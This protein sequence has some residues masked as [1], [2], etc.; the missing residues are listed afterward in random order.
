MA[1][2]T[3]TDIANLQNESSAVTVLAS[4]NTATEI[5]LENT[6]SRDGLTPNH[7]NSELDMNSNRIINLPDATTEQEPITYGQFLETSAAIEAGA[8]LTG[9][10]IVAEAEPALGSSRILTAGTGINIIDEGTT[11]T[12]ESSGLGSDVVTLNDT[13]TLTNKTLT[14]PTL[15]SPVLG[16]PAAA[17]LINATG[18]PLSTGVVGNLAVANLN[19][20]T[21][22]SSSTFWRGDGTWST[23]AVPT[24]VT[25]IAGTS[26]VITLG[27]GLS[28]AGSVLSGGSSK[29]YILN[30]AM[31]VSQENG[32]AVGTGNGYY[33]VDQFNWGAGGWTGSVNVAQVASRTPSGS[34][35]RIRATIT[36]ADASVGAS[37]FLY[38]RTTLEGTK[39]ADLNFGSASAKTV[40]LQFGVKAPAG[41]YAV[42]FRNAVPDR[43]WKGEYTIT[44][45]ETNTDVV[46]SVTLTVDTTGTWTTGTTLG[47]N[48][49]WTLMAG[50]TFTSSATGWFSASGELA[51]SSQFNFAGTLGN[52]FEL[53]DVSLTQGSTAPTF[54]V[55]DFEEELNRCKRYWE[56]SWDYST[57]V[58]TS[59]LNG[60]EQIYIY[61]PAGFVQG[62]LGARYKVEKRGQ[63]TIQT[64]SPTT[65][66]SGKVRDAINGVD[67][68]PVVDSNGTNG[69]R[70]YGA[71]TSGLGVALAAHWTA[72][73]RM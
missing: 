65:G 18:L 24:S 54:V 58:G 13:Q 47:C 4:N 73:A 20:G 3:L 21:S 69:F 60:C 36:G 45:G 16:T 31:M 29:N 72:S 59:T 8:V 34:P 66:V 33:P 5:A 51:T 28:M 63:P 40:T 14:A 1:K 17:D 37:D 23:P 12:I 44:G 15:T 64:W 10:Y 38:F 48:I 56:K 27:S 61:G 53:F 2:L 62:G 46:K 50:S 32:A 30:G 35:S 42:I 26:G 57:A 7:M 6:L 11:L 25:S 9:S 22:A 19:S 71:F 43:T 41:T 68:T 49:Y 55:P 39:I 52:V 67:I 70:W